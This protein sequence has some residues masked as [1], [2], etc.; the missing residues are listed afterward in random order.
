MPCP[1][2][3]ALRFLQ[4]GGPAE[5]AAGARRSRPGSGERTAKARSPAACVEFQC[6]CDKHLRQ[7]GPLCY[8]ATATVFGRCGAAPQIFFPRRDLAFALGKLLL[9]CPVASAMRRSTSL[10]LQAAR[11]SFCFWLVN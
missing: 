8:R 1:G 2:G 10:S 7:G 9:E 6:S 5:I 11:L 4:H 3:W